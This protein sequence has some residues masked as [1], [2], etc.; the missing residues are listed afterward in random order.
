[1]TV[2]RRLMPLCVFL[3]TLASRPAHALDPSKHV[4]QYGHTAWRIRDGSLPGQALAIAQTADG[5]L[6][7]GTPSGLLHFDGVRFVAWTPPAG[8]QLA[9]PSIYSLRAAR[10]GSLWIGTETGLSRWANQELTNFQTGRGLISSILEARNGTVWFTRTR[11]LDDAGCLCQVIGTGMRCYGKA[12]GIPFSEAGGLVEDA[13]GNLWFGSSTGLVRWK[14]GS[15]D[16]YAPS[17]LR[18]NENL[19]GVMGLAANPDGSLW[20]GIALTGFG[21]GLQQLV[22]GVW[23]Q[24]V[25]PELDGSTLSVHSLFLDR[26]NTLWIGAYGKGIYRVQGRR[27][28]HFS[29]AD[30]LS[31]DSVIGF[32]QDRE[33]SLWVA[34]TKGIDMFRDLRVATFSTREGLSTEEVDSVLAS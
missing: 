5:Y 24:F 25:T 21:L 30:G 2:A 9:S 28:D 32:Y 16:V 27:V 1:M 4:S 19:G 3:L 20:V 23:E 11:P 17:G 22:R 8:Q 26:D 6:W 12:N 10:D 18:S 14:P 13:L 29:T 7:I 15:R 31:S 33:G 34:T